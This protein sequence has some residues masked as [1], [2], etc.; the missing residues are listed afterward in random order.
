MGLLA[1]FRGALEKVTKVF[2]PDKTTD[3]ELIRS[4]I[5]LPNNRYWRRAVMRS[6]R[7]RGPGYTRSMRKGRTRRERA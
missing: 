7:L 3:A 5:E 4:G 6:Q 2:R 1:R